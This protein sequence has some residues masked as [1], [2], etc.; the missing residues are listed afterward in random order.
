MKQEKA[1]KKDKEKKKMRRVVMET[2][3]LCALIAVIGAFGMLSG[4]AAFIGIRFQECNAAVLTGIGCTLG[5]ILWGSLL[6]LNRH[7]MSNEG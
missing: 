5:G 4:A 7:N 1:E 3:A 2:V 6:I